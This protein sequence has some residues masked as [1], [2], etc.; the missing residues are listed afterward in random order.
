MFSL[1]NAMLYG[2]ILAVVVIGGLAYVL[3]GLKRGGEANALGVN[4]ADSIGGDM[5]VVR[6]GDEP[7]DS[8]DASLQVSTPLLRDAVR[9]EVAMARHRAVL[10]RRLGLIVAIVV[11]M[12]IVAAA[13]FV[14]RVPALIAIATPVPLLAW[15]LWTRID[16]RVSGRRLDRRLA[17]LDKG[18]D[19]QTQL[20]TVAVDEKPAAAAP[21]NHDERSIELS[22]PIPGLTTLMDRMPVAPATYVNRAI[23][24]RSVRTV[25]LSAPALAAGPAF[26]VSADYPQDVLPFDLPTNVDRA[27]KQLADLATDSQEESDELPRAVGE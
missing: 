10:H 8:Q 11:A 25:D 27:L 18:W 5:V 9:R 15:G 21:V 19:E 6:S 17:S 22:V 1:M 2:L 4:S 12:G 16:V 20:I 24:P 7:D 23:M 26:P 3:V 13:I 14:S